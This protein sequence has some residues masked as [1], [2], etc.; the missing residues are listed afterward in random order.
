MIKGVGI[1]I[2]EVARI[3]GIMEK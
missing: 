3:K 1:D 2:I